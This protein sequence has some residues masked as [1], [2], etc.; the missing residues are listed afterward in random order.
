MTEMYMYFSIRLIRRFILDRSR[1]IVVRIAT[2]QRAGCL[3]KCGSIPGQARDL[4][5]LHCV[6]SGVVVAHPVFYLMS[7]GYFFPQG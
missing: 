5:Y 7:N 4:S 1:G 2:T 3:K 6:Q